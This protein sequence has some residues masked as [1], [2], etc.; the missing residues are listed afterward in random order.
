MDAIYQAADVD[1]NFFKAQVREL[2]AE[3]NQSTLTSLF[4]T[5]TGTRQE[6]GKKKASC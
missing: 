2:D 3:R 4:R 5:I 6:E 1:F